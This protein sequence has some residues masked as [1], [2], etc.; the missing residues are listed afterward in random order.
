MKSI[1]IAAEKANGRVSA[2]VERMK[3]DYQ[4]ALFFSERQIKKTL[5]ERTDVEALI[6][7]TP[8]ECGY[9][10]SLISHVKELNGYVFALPVMLLTDAEHMERDEQYLDE[11]AIGLIE[12]DDSR[13]IILQKLRIAVSVIN[14]VSFA[15]FSKMLKALPSLIYLKDAKGRYVF[16]SQYLH[17]LDIPDDPNWTIRGKTDM[18]VRRDQEN[19]RKAFASDMQI[20]A[21]GRGTSYVIEEHEDGVH[22]YLQLIK[23][24]LKDEQGRVT[25]IIAII[26]NVTEQ[27]T[28][29]RELRKKSMTDELTGLYNRSY[30]DECIEKVGDMSYPL[31]VISADCDGLKA[32]NDSYGHMVG[33]EYLRM[34]ATLFKTVLPQGCLKFR[35]GGDEFIFLMPG[36][37]AEDAKHYVA[38]LEHDAKS[39]VIKDRALSV[40]YGVAVAEHP[41]V[42]I[43]D[44]IADSDAEMYKNKYEKKKASSR[45]GGEAGVNADSKSGE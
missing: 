1:L 29:R 11:A 24:P 30:F 9:A 32:I 7:D 6:I 16:C 10:R 38:R 23:E 44:C 8:S 35:T 22:E 15:E 5:S 13:R 25:G 28:L 43:T 31:T 3:D 34:A 14:S 33:D 45:V 17:H 36:V 2:F 42:S 19:A 21:T 12:E 27:E 37:A 4:V 39:F 26:N 20:V 18:E 41:G 40:S